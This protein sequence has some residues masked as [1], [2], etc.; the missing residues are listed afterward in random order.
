[1]VTHSVAGAIPNYSEQRHKI[2]SARIA[3]DCLGQVMATQFKPVRFF[4]LMGVAAFVVCTV[5]V[6]YTHRGAHGRTAQE[7]TAYEIGEN[8]GEQALRDARLPTDGELKMI[9]EKYFGK[10]ELGVQLRILRK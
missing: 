3:Y 9:A 1:V 10:E 5:A 2:L 6:L 8:A 7:R 4:V